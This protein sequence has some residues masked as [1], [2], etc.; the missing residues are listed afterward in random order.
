ML[1][2]C[3]YA[4][5][6]ACACVCVHVYVYVCMYV[7]VCEY[8]YVL[9]DSIC[10]L[11]M[12]K[13]FRDAEMPSTHTHTHTHPRSECVPCTNAAPWSQREMCSSVLWQ[14][15]ERVWQVGEDS[16]SSHLLPSPPFMCDLMMCHGLLNF[17]LPF[18][19][20]TQP[21][22]RLHTL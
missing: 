8:G 1:K 13:S 12:A 6:C 18:Q 3:M 17:C 2:G 10:T 14:V 20:P 21:P 4:C 11:H 15:G 22:S 9:E 5:A 7:C 16:E 19:L